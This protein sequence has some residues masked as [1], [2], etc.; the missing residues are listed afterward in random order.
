MDAG[1]LHAY[2]K[3]NCLECISI[4]ILRGMANSDYVVSAG[5]TPK[6]KDKSTLLNISTFNMGPVR[7]F[8]RSSYNNKL[9]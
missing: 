6:F 4:M 5:F 3:G 7:E 2:L 1:I 9:E 8:N